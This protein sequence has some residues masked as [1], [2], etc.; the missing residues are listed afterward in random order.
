MAAEYIYDFKIH[1]DDG[2][3]MTLKRSLHCWLPS[4]IVGIVRLWCFIQHLP[5]QAVE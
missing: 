5:E 4:G 2:D 3:I 1:T